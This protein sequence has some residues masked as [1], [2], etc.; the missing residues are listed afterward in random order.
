MILYLASAT[1]AALLAY[2]ADRASKDMA[3]AAVPLGTTLD[4]VGPWVRLAHVHNSGMIFGLFPGTGPMLALLTVPV[5]AV[6]ALQYVRG[7]R[8]SLAALILLGVVL[9]AGSG[10]SLDRATLGYVEDFVDI[11]LVSGP[12]F[13]TFNLSDVALVLGLGMAA[14]GVSMRRP[15]QPSSRRG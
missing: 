12:R 7:A 14:L 3:T 11:G 15:A 8:R 4:I 10:N 9:G 13:W 5:L 1:L 2:G 6:M